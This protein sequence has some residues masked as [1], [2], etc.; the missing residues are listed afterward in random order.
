MLNWNW[1]LRDYHIRVQ[2][3]WLQKTRSAASNA[4]APEAR[5][6][7]KV[8]QTL[9]TKGTKPCTKVHQKYWFNVHAR[10]C[11]GHSSLHAT[12][13]LIGKDLKNKFTWYDQLVLTKKFANTKLKKNREVA[14][15]KELWMLE[16]SKGMAWG[17]VL[18]STLWH[19]DCAIWCVAHHQSQYWLWCHHRSWCWPRC[20]HWSWCWPRCYHWSQHWLGCC[21]WSWCMLTKVLS[22]EAVL[23]NMLSLELALTEM[24]SLLGAGVDRGVVIGAS[25]DQGVVIGPSD[26]GGVIIRAKVDQG[27]VIG[28]GVDQVAVISQNLSLPSSTGLVTGLSLPTLPVN[29]TTLLLPGASTNHSLVA[30]TAML[31]E[32]TTAMLASSS[33]NTPLH[34]SLTIPASL[35]HISTGGAMPS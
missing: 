5:K 16:P 28:A 18:Q 7:Q 12:Q 11:S 26:D 3:N 14:D 17:N 23:T 32:Q 35:L 9:C 10:T 34:H 2:K 29:G 30:T 33:G 6:Q 27:A 1:Q 25:V 13:T 21:H 15:A 22:L 24:L 20:C 8:H 4:G 31:H 19:K